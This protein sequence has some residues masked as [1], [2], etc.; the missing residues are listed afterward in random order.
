MASRTMPALFT[1]TSRRPKSSTAWLDEGLGP[2][3]VGHVV[4]VGRG[5]ATVAADDLGHLLGRG[6]VDTAAVDRAADVVDHDRR[7]LA[8][9]LERLTPADAVARPGDDRHLAVEHS[10]R[11]VLS[12]SLGSRVPSARRAR[13]SRRRP[14]P[15]SR[16]ARPGRL[17]P[18]GRAHGRCRSTC[19]DARR[20]GRRPSTPPRCAGSRASRGGGAGSRWTT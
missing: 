16:P 9:Q 12:L 5:L 3:P 10:H 13:P 20:R 15:G 4:V 2:L 1:R 6:L 14:V 17:S 7:P 18:G 8:G 11:R 19:G